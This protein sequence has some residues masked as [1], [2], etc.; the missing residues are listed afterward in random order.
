MLSRRRKKETKRPVH[1]T[2]GSLRPEERRAVR[3]GEGHCGVYRV[4][5]VLEAEWGSRSPPCEWDVMCKAGGVLMA[6][7]D[8]VTRV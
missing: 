8:G 4:R 1:A 5:P 2:L 7:C 3:R 6:L